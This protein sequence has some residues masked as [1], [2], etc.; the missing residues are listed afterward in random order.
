[1]FLPR[2]PA[3]NKLLLQSNCNLNAYLFTF[4]G[5]L[6]NWPRFNLM[7]VSTSLVPSCGLNDVGGLSWK[8]MT[9]LWTFGF[10]LG[11]MS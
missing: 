4:A 10:G 7:K 6:L 5:L 11:N 3:D 8:Q 9:S 1:M 2:N